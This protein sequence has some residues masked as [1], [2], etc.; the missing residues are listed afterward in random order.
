M[1]GVSGNF[2]SLYYPNSS[3]ATG[4][5]NSRSSGG[6]AFFSRRMRSRYYVGVNYQYENVLAYQSQTTSN[7]T[8]S[9]IQTVFG[10]VSIYLKPTL[11][12][13][14]SSGPQHYSATQFPFPP[15][16]S[17]SPLF[18]TSLGWQG[19]RSAAAVSYSRT[20][21]GGGGLNGIF[22]SNSL[23]ASASRQLSRTWTAALSASYG[24]YD[25]VTPLFILS[26]PGGHTVTGSASLHKSL[27]DHLNVQFGY[28]WVQQAYT[29]VAASLAPNTNR[30]SVSL[31]YQFTRPL[32]R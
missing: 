3:Q 17:W 5:Y 2:S 30:V 7:Q 29:Q 1:V 16:A 23:S 9:Q 25:N 14:I 10:F 18:M 6:S 24:N 31:S 20:V 12:L 21:S 22:R 26:I 4:V 15:A 19:E 32:Q 28:S 11:S 13:S 8:R 27:N